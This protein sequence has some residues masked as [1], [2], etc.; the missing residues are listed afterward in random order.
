MTIDELLALTGLT[1][2]DEIPV[3]DAEASGEPTKK[4]TAQYFA[5]AI[6]TLANLLGTGDVVDDLTSTATDKPLSANQG[7][8]LKNQI[9]SHEY[10]RTNGSSTSITSYST[11]SNPYTVPE[12]GYIRV[13]GTNETIQWLASDGVNYAVLAKSDGATTV[14]VFVRKGMTIFIENPSGARYMQFRAPT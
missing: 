3:W 4:I 6:K 11:S 9:T 10:N 1:G 12:D 2:S 5:A 8:L 13:T 7:R 14:S